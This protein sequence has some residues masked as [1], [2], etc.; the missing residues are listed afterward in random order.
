MQKGPARSA[1]PT[2]LPSEDGHDHGHHHQGR[3]RAD[4]TRLW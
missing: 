1:G 3:G 4:R 2:I